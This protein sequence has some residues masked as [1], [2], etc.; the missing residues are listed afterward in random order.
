MKELRNDT[1]QSQSF[2]R[3]FNLFYDSFY[4]PRDI[5]THTSD[6]YGW[7]ISQMRD[8]KLAAA[9]DTTISSDRMIILN[10]QREK[11]TETRAI[12]TKKN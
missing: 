2:P 5:N 3:S 10:F 1:S 12:S 7:K 9:A 4:L 6:I 11:I 8:G